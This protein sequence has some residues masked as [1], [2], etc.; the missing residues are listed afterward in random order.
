MAAQVR[1]RR[2]YDGPLPGDGIRVLVDRLWPRGLAKDAASVDV[3]AKD[4]APSA[5]LRKWYGHDPR[6]FAEFRRRYEAELAEPVPG[7]V[8]DGLRRLA[9]NGAVT[10]LTAT[11][12]IEHSQAAVLAIHL[13]GQEDTAAS[14]APFTDGQ[15]L[16]WGPAEGGEPACWAHL[17]CA[18][19]GAVTSEGHRQGCRSTPVQPR[20]C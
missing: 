13:L 6:R 1:L 10:L 20:P 17:V 19:C 15:T 5:A 8:L 16:G 4:V 3:W 18:E 2:V 12:D 11:E 7:A 14:R 9:R